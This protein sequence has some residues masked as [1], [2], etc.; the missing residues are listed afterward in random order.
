MMSQR[1]SAAAVLLSMCVSLGLVGAA[2]GQIAQGT[3]FTYQGELRDANFPTTGQYDLRFRLF[4]AAAGGAQVGVTICRD[5]VNVADGLFSASLDFGASAFVGSKRWVEISVRLGGPMGNCTTGAYTLLTPRQELTPAPG[6]IFSNL[7]GGAIGTFTILEGSPARVSFGTSGL[8][9]VGIDST[10]PTGVL[11]RDPVGIRILP[12][13]PT[14]PIPS[15]VLFGPTD[16]C[17]IGIDPALSGLILRDPRGT[18]IIAAAPTLLFGPTDLCTIGIDPQIPGLILRDPRGGRLINP[19]AAN[20]TRMFFGP[21]DDCS[22]GI[23]PA[24]TGIVLRDPKG[25]RIDPP[26][27]PIPMPTRLFFGPTDDCSLG[28][29]PVITGLIGRDPRGFR[30]LPPNP[31]DPPTLLFGASDLCTV[32]TSPTLA[33]LLLSDPR[34]IRILNPIPSDLPRLIFG[35][36]DGCSI[37]LTQVD[38]LT[39][40]RMSDPV[41]IQITN[42]NPSVNSA[43]FL[44]DGLSCSIQVTPS[45]VQRPGMILTDPRGFGFNGGFVTMGVV[46]SPQVRLQLPTTNDPSGQALANRWIDASSRRWKENIRPIDDAMEKLSQLKGVYFDWKKD[47]GG[48]AGMG[49]IAEE[50]GEVFPEVVAW[51]ANGKD[52]SGISYDHLV[53]VAVEAIKSQHTHITTL[54]AE[55]AELKARLERIERLL[56]VNP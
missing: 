15:R 10:G 39:M 7:A 54:K 53:A 12:P 51:E 14:P 25:A 37:G 13:F 55:N 31:G 23:D 28:I 19:V 9:T 35:P 43:L 50:V 21:T 47:H 3:A 32:A 46:Q 11:L 20:P 24:R 6:A 1:F 33:G 48:N 34:G 17:T 16:L 36:T 26:A 2:A 52:A 44:G 29:D 42:P 4:A 49:F 27:M 41:G 40:I 8:C 5:N 22:I 18:R 38:N 30:I 56:Q 45:T